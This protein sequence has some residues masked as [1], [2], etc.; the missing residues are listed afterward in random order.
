M[1]KNTFI[2]FPG[3]G[4]RGERELWRRGILTWE[5]F[6]RHR[7]PNLSLFPSAEDTKTYREL[8]ASEHALLSRDAAFF[9]T[10]IPKQEQFR[11]AMS[12]PDETVF[13]DIETTGLSHY[14]DQVTVIGLSVLDQYIFCIQ[15]Q[16]L[17]RIAQIISN[18]KCLVTFNGTLFDIPFIKKLIPDI[19]LPSVHIDLRY[20][21]RRVGLM[22]GQKP[23]EQEIGLVRIEE[24]QDLSGE[25]APVL[26]HT[27]KAGSM[28]A[29]RRLISYNHSDI[30]GMKSILDEAVNRWISSIKPAVPFERVRFANHTS[31]IKWET[32]KSSP[33]K[34]FIPSG[35]LIPYAGPSVPTLKYNDLVAKCRHPLRIVGIDL[36]GS[37]NRATGFSLLDGNFATTKRILTDDELVEATLSSRPN[38]VSIDSPLSLPAGRR[39]VTDDDPGRHEFG[40]MREC[41]RILKRRGVNVYPALINSMQRLT[42]RGMNLAKRLRQLGLPVIESYPGAAQDILGIP[43]KRASLE[44]L[45]KGLRDFG[46]TGDFIKQEVSHDE[47]D[48]ITSAIVGLFFWDG[49]FEALGNETEDYLIIPDLKISNL[50]WHKRFVVGLS[51]HIAAGKTTIGRYLQKHGFTYGRF[52]LVLEEVLSR[53][54]QPV[55]RESLQEIG[56][57]LHDDPGQRALCWKLVKQFNSAECIVIDG[58][59][60]PEDHSFMLE[61]FGPAFIHVHIQCAD[62]TRRHRYMDKNGSDI[63]FDDA[64]SAPVEAEIHNLG[65]LA[66]IELQNE[67]EL[68][69][70]YLKLDSLLKKNNP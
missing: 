43:R 64:S 1:L 44:Y 18:A 32:G 45:A 47:L 35:Q 19:I 23:I 49:R 58:M 62:Q 41:E 68:E 12:F 40:I 17:G 36:T 5:D 60:Y 65:T 66:H 21:C 70:L 28:D 38:L 63:S 52:S 48:A 59:R 27:Y 7:Q 31:K 22:G 42:Q 37:E 6:H 26:W 29:L 10:R 9:G 11:I 2:H 33:K 25:A 51:G 13:L 34:R 46:I 30:E 53:M 8:T 61:Q 20:F 39:S 24:I 54:E 15:G 69:T 4:I 57:A 56:K 16:D 14:Y 67:D 3:I 55:T 50:R